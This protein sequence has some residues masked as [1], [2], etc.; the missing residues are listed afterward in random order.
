MDQSGST[1][2]T[3]IG[4]ASVQ[5]SK[6]KK[7]TIIVS[8]QNAVRS[9]LHIKFT[10]IA[11]NNGTKNITLNG[12]EAVYFSVDLNN[13]NYLVD[14]FDKNFEVNLYGD[15]FDNLLEVYKNGNEFCFY[16]DGHHKSV[17]LEI[18]NRDSNK[19]QNAKITLGDGLAVE[20]D[21]N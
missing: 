6:G 3:G 4:N 12:G 8:G 7:Y 1:L 14:T 15:S 21:K 16:N 9:S 13:R 20:L 10:P 2:W 19:V 18:V 11:F 17:V 5:L